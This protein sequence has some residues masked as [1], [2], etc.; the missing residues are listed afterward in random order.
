MV[1]L[2]DITGIVNDALIFDSGIL[3]LIVLY[4]GTEVAGGFPPRSYHSLEATDATM[5]PVLFFDAY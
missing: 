4:P 1:Q 5:R 3:K 2:P